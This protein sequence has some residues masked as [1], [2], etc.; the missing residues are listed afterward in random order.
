MIML[1]WI[2]GDATMRPDWYACK[3]ALVLLCYTCEHAT[4][5]LRLN[6]RGASTIALNSSA[7]SNRTRVATQRGSRRL[8]GLH[9]EGHC[10]M[11]R[12]FLRA[13][14]RRAHLDQV[15]RRKSLETYTTSL[16]LPALQGSPSV[17]SFLTSASAT[18]HTPHTL[19]LCAPPHQRT[20]SIA[21]IIPDHPGQDPMDHCTS[22]ITWVVPEVSSS[23]ENEEG[24]SIPHEDKEDG[25][26]H[27]KE[28]SLER[29]EEGCK[30]GR[31]EE[32][33]I[34][35]ASSSPPSPL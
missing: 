24:K 10:F 11:K 1:G 29:G 14:F 20:W 7:S 18:R 15:P 33:E 3:S 30:E 8:D 25:T 2:W 16:Q 9:E 28:I 6:L 32:S 13:F 12:L 26:D 4:G 35:E 17:S 27:H 19:S 34:K 5:I 21:T 31:E 23:L 22:G